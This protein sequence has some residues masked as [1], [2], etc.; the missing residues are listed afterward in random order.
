M[1]ICDDG[2][3]GNGANQVCDKPFVC[4]SMCYLENKFSSVL[5]MMNA[6]IE[7]IPV[8]IT[9]NVPMFQA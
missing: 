1:C 4:R 7:L 3:Y 8:L 2:F 9:L 5:M 6:L